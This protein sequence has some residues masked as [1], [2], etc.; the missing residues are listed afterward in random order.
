MLDLAKANAPE[1]VTVDGVFY[2]IKT[3]FRFWLMFSRLLASQESCFADFD[4]LYQNQWQIPE[5]RKAGFDALLDFFINKKELPRILE[6]NDNKNVLDY[7]LDAELIYAAFYEQYKID[8]LDEKMRLHWWKFKALLSGLHG[9]KLNEIMAFRCFD[10]NDKTEWKQVQIMNRKR[11]EL[12]E[13]VT[14]EEKKAADEFDRLLE[15]KG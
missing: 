14:A 9:T 2:P 15:K 11:W 3:D 8:L 10:E 12:P 7:E 13:K 1:A 4:F 6:E 5:D